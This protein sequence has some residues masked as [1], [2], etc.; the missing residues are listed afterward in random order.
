MNDGRVIPPSRAKRSVASPSRSLATASSTLFCYVSDLVDGI[1]RLMESD[2]SEP[3]NLG[4]PAERN[5]LELADYINR[6]TQNPAGVVHKELPKDDPT[7]ETTLNGHSRSWTGAKVSFEEG[8]AK[9]MAYFKAFF[10]GGF[11]P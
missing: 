8:I 4:N 5:M 1:V 2:L 7:A 10:R 9:T 6:F 3:C 11:E